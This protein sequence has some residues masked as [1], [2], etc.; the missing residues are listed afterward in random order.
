[1]TKFPNCIDVNLSGFWENSAAQ[2][3]LNFETINGSGLRAGE[4]PLPC[5]SSTEQ[6]ENIHLAWFKQWQE[7]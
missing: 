1:M 4:S 7:T 3:P 2:V 5:T 6:R